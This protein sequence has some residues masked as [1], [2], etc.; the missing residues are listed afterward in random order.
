MA[1]PRVVVTGLGAITCLGFNVPDF[2]QSLVEG[3]SGVK[4]ITRFDAKDYPVKIAAQ[5]EGFD[6]LPWMDIKVVD[7]NGRFIQFAIAATLQ[8]V[9]Q[10]GLEMKSERPERVGVTLA[11]SGETHRIGE[12]T[13]VLKT[14]GPRRI[15]PLFIN[16]IAPHMAP[17][18]VG[19]VLGARGPNS[20]INS[21][22]AGGSDAIGT[23]L[24]HLRAGHADVMVA[25]GTDILISEIS[26]AVMG[27]VGALSK[28]PVP[29][30]SPRPF[31][32]AR[33]GFVVGEGCG[34]LL[35]ETL[36][37]A[38]RRGA[39]I[40][41]E[42]AG[43]GWSF[44]AHNDTA[45]LAEGQA[46]AIRMAIEDAGMKAEDVSYVNAHGTGTKLN[47]SA[48]SKA[49]RLALGA[50][51]YRTPVSSNKSMIGH[52]GGAAG[53]VEAVAT[54]M[55][56]LKGVIPPTINY[57]TPD[58]DCDLDYVPNEARK[59]DSRVCISNS[60]GLGGQ[61]ASVLFKRWEGR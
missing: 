19:R 49:I 47:D 4:A 40:L 23:A 61:N 10:A 36:E 17:V 1:V 5:I 34:I 48:E 44:D 38:Q 9:Q 24:T 15:D 7:R 31:D 54:V 8:A 41:C 22:C 26:I 43:A 35:L 45:P 16:R 28:D 60:F 51:A 46:L 32:L 58:P 13:E 37:H 50:H 11:T 57:R 53:S 2:Y 6:P 20:S 25:G 39:A 30:G 18:Q 3:R 21:A 27:L 52:L 29:E 55:T 59:A 14:R 12:G 33:N 56:I 42:L